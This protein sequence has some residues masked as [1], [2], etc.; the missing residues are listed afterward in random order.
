MT[1]TAPHI[2]LAFREQPSLKRIRYENKA[3]HGLRDDFSPC[4]LPS[5]LIHPRQREDKES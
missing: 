4:V 5:I 1:L 3:M 2:S